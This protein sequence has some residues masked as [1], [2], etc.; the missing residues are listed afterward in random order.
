MDGSST[1]NFLTPKH[2]IMF[3]LQFSSDYSQAQYYALKDS[4]ARSPPLEHNH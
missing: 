2:M 3:N 1:S 4:T